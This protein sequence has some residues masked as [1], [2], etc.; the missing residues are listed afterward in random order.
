MTRYQ[1]GFLTKCAAHGV[2]GRKLLKKAQTVTYAASPFLPTPA[3]ASGLLMPSPVRDVMLPDKNKVIAAGPQTAQGAAKAEQPT[4]ANPNG[5]VTMARGQDGKMTVVNPASLPNQTWNQ[6]LGMSGR[7]GNMLLGAG[8]GS[9]ILLLHEA[10]R[11]RRSKDERKHYLMKAL[12]GGLGGVA[13]GALADKGTRANLAR[14]MT[15]KK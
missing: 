8:I 1:Y 12:L 13:V 5:G 6:R 9:T 7:G 15:G 3:Y 10:L 2:D 4:L 11:R 14:M